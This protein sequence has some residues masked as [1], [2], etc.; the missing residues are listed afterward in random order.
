MLKMPKIPPL[1]PHVNTVEVMPI[2]QGVGN[3]LLTY[4]SSK[5]IPVGSIVG[6]PLR[7]KTVN[8]IVVSS[9]NASLSKTDLKRADY[10]IKKIGSVKTGIFFPPHFVKAA[11]KTAYYFATSGG[12]VIE[13]LTPKVVLD[14]YLKKQKV[15]HSLRKKIGEGPN[16]KSERFL[17]Q[18]DEEDRISSYKNL[19]R[20]EF[21]RQKSVYIC[22]PTINDVARIAPLL[23]HGIQNY[24][25]IFHGKLPK[26]ELLASWDAAQKERHPILIIATGL[27]FSLPRFDI[28]VI[29]IERE[30]TPAYKIQRRPYIDVRVF[31]ELFAKE[32]GANFIFGDSFLRTETLYRKDAGEFLEFAPLAFRFLSGTEQKVAVVKNERLKNGGFSLIGSELLNLIKKT[33]ENSE[34]LFILTARRGLYPITICNDCG[35]TVLC[36]RC[37]APLV[38]HKQ[39]SKT[40]GVSPENIFLCHKCGIKKESPD[41]CVVCKSWRLNTLGAGTER[42]EEEIK[43]LIPGITTFRIDKD[44]TKQEKKVREIVERFEKSPASILI[45]TEMAL[46]YIDTVTNIAAVSLD[47][48]FALPDFRIPERVLGLLLKIRGKATKIF[49]IQTRIEN[50]SVWKYA[51]EGNSVGFYREEI[52]NR[53]RFAYPPF[54][55][56]IKI[57]WCGTRL[58]IG[59]E[60][61][62]LKKFLARYKPQF[63]PAFTGKVRGK[64]IMNALVRLPRAKWPDADLLK[65]L[66]ALPPSFAINIGPE[67]TL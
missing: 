59:N 67:D 17:F 16:N 33:K 65:L 40:K 35:E 5:E 51:M 26:K 41:E 63:F 62:K 27:F 13:T 46:P 42:I 66:Y 44:A 14:D 54:T 45:G 52:E 22:M 31:A 15:S 32:I 64:Y 8:G 55:T 49:L 60:A 11:E 9:Q 30:N 58:S 20:G 50:L 3:E 61:E 36:E 23:G 39:S 25:Y 4:F 53:K 10:Q 19:I 47:S 57:T 6:I 29:I 48:L 56:L 7:N 43:R 24:T 12:A 1:T 37:S 38:L 18:S 21:A 2:A 28:S 34:R